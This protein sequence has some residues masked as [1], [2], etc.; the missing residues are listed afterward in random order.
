MID[1]YGLYTETPRCS[2]KV[3]ERGG[4]EV[5]LCTK[6][7]DELTLDKFYTVRDGWMSACKKCTKA[8]MNKRYKRKGYRQGKPCRIRV[9]AVDVA[10]G[11]NSRKPDR[12]IEVGE[13]FRSMAWAECS[14]G[15]SKQQISNQVTG[16]IPHARGVRFKYLEE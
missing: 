5:K 14:T 11:Y 10:R 8:A 6:C 2:T 9:V 15:I 12:E 7:G 1:Q 3:Y 13:E 4:E 16:K